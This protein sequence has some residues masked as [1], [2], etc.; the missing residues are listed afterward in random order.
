MVKM[1]LKS[2]Y[3]IF[4]NHFVIRKAA[5]C[6]IA[7]SFNCYYY[8]FICFFFRSP[9]LLD[10]ELFCISTSDETRAL[11]IF[12]VICSNSLDKSASA[13]LNVHQE[14]NHGLFKFALTRL[15]TVNNACFTLQQTYQA[16]LVHPRGQ[17]M[18]PMSP[19]R[20]KNESGRWWLIIKLFEAMKI[21]T[22]T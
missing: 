5:D 12:V 14:N 11:Q 10:C 15:Y 20:E 16:F 17:P 22:R 3:P 1:I 6:K 2:F 19:P 8:L 18:N 7:C 13:E 21:S 9:W 4:E